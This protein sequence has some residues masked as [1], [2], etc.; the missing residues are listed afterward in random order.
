[1]SDPFTLV[2]NALDSLLWAS[3][4]VRSLVRPGNRLSFNSTKTLNPIK[5]E[6]S[7]SDLPEMILEITSLTGNLFATSSSSEVTRQF[8]VLLSTGNMQATQMLLPLEFAVFAAM[9]NWKSVLLALRWID[10]DRAFVTRANLVSAECGIRD[11]EKNRGLT[12]WSAI[13][14]VDIRM[15]FK[16]SD[17]IN[18]G[19]GT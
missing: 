14:T 13:W 6:V 18:Y 10:P 7:E 12:G 3:S 4:E 17:L 15:D 11:I 9:A 1:M 5:D 2:Y 19:A 8:Q 16:T